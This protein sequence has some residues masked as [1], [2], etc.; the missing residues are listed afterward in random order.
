MTCTNRVES[1]KMTRT[2]RESFHVVQACS[3]SY[4]YRPWSLGIKEHLLV[5][6]S[7]IH[8]YLEEK[9]LGTMGY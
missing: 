6:M 4:A 1:F 5:E 9:F 7:Q 2:N 3:L 8:V